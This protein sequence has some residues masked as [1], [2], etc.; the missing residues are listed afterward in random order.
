MMGSLFLRKRRVIRRG[1][2]LR[3]SCSTEFLGLS[4]SVLRTGYAVLGTWYACT[5]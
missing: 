5:R 3:N 1:G 2:A 4:Y